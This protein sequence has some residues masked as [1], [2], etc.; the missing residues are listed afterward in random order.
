MRVA[1]PLTVEVKGVENFGKNFSNSL[2]FLEKICY[3]IHRK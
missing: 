1:T 2:D 3:N